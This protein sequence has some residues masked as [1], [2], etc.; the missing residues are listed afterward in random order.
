MYHR[1]TD[2]FS[3]LTR[4][5]RRRAQISKLST[6]PVICVIDYVWFHKRFHEKVIL[7]IVVVLLGVAIACVAPSLPPS[8]SPAA[9]LCRHA[10]VSP[11][12]RGHGEGCWSA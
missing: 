3:G 1:W 7:S 4:R 2:S 9:S 10:H 6:I 5:R 12:F 8:P 11:T